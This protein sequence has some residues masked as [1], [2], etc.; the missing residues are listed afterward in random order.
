MENFEELLNTSTLENKEGVVKGIIV[1]KTKD[2]VLIDLKSKAERFISKNEFLFDEWENIKDGDEISVYVEGNKISYANARKLITLDELIQFQKNSTPIEV[3]VTREVKGGYLLNYK[4]IELFMPKALASKSELKKDDIV[5]GIIKSVE[6]GKKIIFS[7]ADYLNKLKEL[8]LNNFFNTKKVGDVVSGDIRKIIDKGVFINVED[9]DCFV[10]FSEL[11]YK[12]IKSPDELFKIGDTVKAKII[13]MKPELKKVTLSIKALEENPWERFL[14]NYKESDKVKGIVRNIID[15][16]V[17][18][19]IEDGLDGFLHV[20][21]ISWT[22]RIK[23]PKKYFKIGDYV[24]CIIKKIDRNNKKISL[25]FK[26]LLPNPWQEFLSLHNI[27]SVLKA[28]IKKV[29]ERGVILEL[30]NSLEGF[31]P[32][33]HIS[34][35][36]VEDAKKMLKEGDEINV[37]LIAGDEARRRLV[38]SIKDLTEDPWE[39]YASSKKLGDEVEGII[40]EI[41]EKLIIVELAQYVEGIVKKSE[42]QKERKEQLPAVG[43]KLSFIIKEIDNQKKRL[44]L[45]YLDLLKKRD[46]EALAELKKTNIT[47]VTL[48]DFFK[49]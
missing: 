9:V 16:G 3:K 30:E 11:T 47:K 19:E 44:V 13:E 24:E 7:I 17:F 20:S 31:I 45:S 22:E 39:V 32:N 12:R 26:D 23:S 38:F 6:E 5:K 36:Y 18:I 40:K 46:E 43:D 33:E 10:P 14:R 25:S 27:G 21:E 49:K 2:G 15:T 1:R 48:G 41:S 35:K 29:V 4:G 37:K 8:A 42:F 34:W 28:K